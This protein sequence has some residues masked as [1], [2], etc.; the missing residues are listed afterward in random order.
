MTVNDVKTD[1]TNLGI[2]PSFLSWW[3]Q[4]WGIN[5]QAVQYFSIVNAPPVNNGRRL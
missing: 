2:Y 5:G 1:L 3:N 4:F